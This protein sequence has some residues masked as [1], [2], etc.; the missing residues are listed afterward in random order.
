LARPQKNLGRF[1]A[2][3]HCVDMDTNTKPEASQKDTT[4]QPVS[5]TTE[6]QPV[7]RLTIK[8]AVRAGWEGHNRYAGPTGGG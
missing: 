1:S 2:C 3:S 5:K 4:T 7:R 6:S 8:A